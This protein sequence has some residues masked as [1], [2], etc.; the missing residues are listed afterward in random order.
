MRP[1]IITGYAREL[2][3]PAVVAAHA[4]T[5]IAAAIPHA[6]TTTAVAVPHAISAVVRSRGWRI[7][8]DRSNLIE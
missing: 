5:T 3:R 4:I 1:A 8:A 6:I 2:I 7:G